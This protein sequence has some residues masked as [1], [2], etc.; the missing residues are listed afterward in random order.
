LNLD[1]R[2]TVTITFNAFKYNAIYAVPNVSDAFW[3]PF[4]STSRN[5]VPLPANTDLTL[6]LELKT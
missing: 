6:K 3:F 1:F 2:Y 5:S 4:V